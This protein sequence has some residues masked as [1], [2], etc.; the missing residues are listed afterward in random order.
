MKHHKGFTVLELIIVI[1]FVGIGVV[2]FFLQKIN[3]DAMDRDERRKISINA[4]YY[5]LEEGYFVQN[6][7]YP[8]FIEAAETLPWMDPNLFT[9]PFGTNLWVEGSNYRYQATDCTDGKC[10]HYTLR[11]TMEREEDFIRTSRN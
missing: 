10:L 2:L 3:L 4:M 5:S 7:H 9:D 11:A 1:L 6:N 8:E